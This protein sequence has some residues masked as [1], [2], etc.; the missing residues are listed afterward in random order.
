MSRKMGRPVSENP[1]KS[2]LFIRITE[3]ENK[4]L[5]YCCEKTS[6]TKADIAREG[7]CLILDRILENK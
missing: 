3:E 4:K 2:K 7:L 1:K 5:E 6:R